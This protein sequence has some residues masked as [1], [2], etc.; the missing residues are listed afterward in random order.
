MFELNAINKRDGIIGLDEFA[1]K[2]DHANWLE[3]PQ[4]KV[5]AITGAVLKLLKFLVNERGVGADTFYFREYCPL[6]SEC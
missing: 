4:E 5:Q 2:L 1:N 6:L 3:W